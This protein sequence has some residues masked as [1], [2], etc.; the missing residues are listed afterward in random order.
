MYGLDPDAMLASG[1]LNGAPDAPLP[2]ATTTGTF[3]QNGGAGNTDASSQA[4][5]TTGQRPSAAGDAPAAAQA[6]R[7]VVG[8]GKAL[9]AIRSLFESR[10]VDG[11]AELLAGNAEDWDLVKDLLGERFLIRRKIPRS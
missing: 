6:A 3:V 7:T 8:D 1:M 4:P 10:I 5:K 9:D 2:V 11:E